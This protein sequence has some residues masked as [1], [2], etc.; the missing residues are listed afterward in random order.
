MRRIL[1]VRKKGYNDDFRYTEYFLHNALQS[2]GY[3][4]TRDELTASFT[5]TAYIDHR[6]NYM[7][8]TSP[9]FDQ[10]PEENIFAYTAAIASAMK[11]EAIFLPHPGEIKTRGTAIFHFHFSNTTNAFAEPA[12]IESGK[13]VL[14]VANKNVSLGGIG[15]FG[16]KVINYGGPSQGIDVIFETTP[17]AAEFLEI[18]VAQIRRYTKKGMVTEK[19]IFKKDHNGY[20]CQ[21]NGFE[22]YPGLNKN[23]ALWC[24]SRTKYQN[25]EFYMDFA[26][27]N[28]MPTSS[29]VVLTVRPHF[30][31]GFSIKLT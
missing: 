12:V 14:E 24:R 8:F 15:S 10:I 22:I 17:L 6:V 18:E 21:V 28:N 1:Q 2:F 26:I 19:L 16:F 13:S 9:F 31:E 30:G 7:L 3:N 25:T 20:I 5:V 23:S 11:S 4:L 29:D 27:K